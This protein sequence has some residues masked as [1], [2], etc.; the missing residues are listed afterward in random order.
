MIASLLA[1]TAVGLW[2]VAVYLLATSGLFAW[3]WGVA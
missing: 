1:D 2:H 3:L